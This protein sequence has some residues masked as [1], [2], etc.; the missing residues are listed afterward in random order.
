MRLETSAIDTLFLELSQFTK[1]T[2]KR[3]RLMLDS[4]E[5]A[6]AIIANAYDGDWDKASPTWREAAERFRNV[7]HKILEVGTPE[8]ATS[9][10]S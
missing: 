5:T 2:T 3:E 7:Y 4:L 1:A 10:V 8:A 9:K 6:W